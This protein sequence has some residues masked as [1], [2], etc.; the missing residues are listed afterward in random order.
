MVCCQIAHPAPLIAIFK[1]IASHTPLLL[2]LVTSSHGRSEAATCLKT[3]T[4][5][6]CETTCPRQWNANVSTEQHWGMACLDDDAEVGM[7]IVD[8]DVEV[9]KP[10]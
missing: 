5:F 7:A 2:N 9:Q 8:V 10:E 3:I 6:M 1:V 4:S